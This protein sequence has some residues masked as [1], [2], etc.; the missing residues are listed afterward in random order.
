MYKERDPVKSGALTLK[1][2][3]L[4]TT[5]AI[6]VD[7]CAQNYYSLLIVLFLTSGIV[8]GSSNRPQSSLWVGF[9]I[10]LGHLEL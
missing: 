2:L 4:S 6:I 3:C 5:V 8:F 10:F 7:S 1:K 9:S